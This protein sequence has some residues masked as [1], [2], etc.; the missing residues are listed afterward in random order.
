MAVGA[1]GG[2]VGSRHTS[3]RAAERLGRRGVSGGRAGLPPD[4]GTVVPL[5][6]REVAG[7]R[8]VR[9]PVSRGAV[10]GLVGP[11][12]P[13][14][15]GASNSGGCVCSGRCAHGVDARVGMGRLWHTVKSCEAGE[16]AAAGCCDPVD[17]AHGDPS[18][19]LKRLLKR[20]PEWHEPPSPSPPCL[21]RHARRL[22]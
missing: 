7:V 3:R 16:C 8:P 1:G 14:A 19:R 9:R 17:T 20:Y 12:A 15:G 10:R 4:A 18:D 11:Q 2:M 5:A 21:R 22:R 13:R 6:R